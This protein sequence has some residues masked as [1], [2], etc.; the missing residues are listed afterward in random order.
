M[1]IG[2]YM[3]VKLKDEEI[4][5][6]NYLDMVDLDFLKQWIDNLKHWHGQV[7]VGGAMVERPDFKSGAKS[8]MILEAALNIV[9]FY[10]TVVRAIPN[11]II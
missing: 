11:T 3:V 2:N 5:D 10:N 7:N 4:K 8:Q 9:W 6:V 1:D